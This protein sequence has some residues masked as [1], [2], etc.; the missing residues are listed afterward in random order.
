MTVQAQFALLSDR[1]FLEQFYDTEYHYGPNQE[2]FAWV[3]YQTGNAAVTFLAEPDVGRSWVS[4]THWLPKVDGYLIGQSLFDRLTYHSWGSVAYAQMD[5]FRNPPDEFPLKFDNGLPPPEHGVNTGRIDWMQKLSAPFDLGPARVVPYGVTDL[6]YFTQDNSYSTAGRVYG[7][8]GVRASVPFSRLYSDVE[9][10]MFNVKGLYHKNV[11]SVNYYAAATNLSWADLPQLDR[12]NDDATESSW[13]DITPWQ[14]A[15]SFLNATNGLVLGTGSYNIYNPRQYA[16]RRL[17]DFNPETLGNIQE[18]QL[19]WRQR[20]QTKRGYP[21][22]E[23]TVD[24]FTLDL[25]GSIFPVPNRDNFGNSVGFLEYAAQWNVGDRTALYSNAWVDPWNF[26]AR[27]WDVGASFS[28]DDRTSFAI[29][30]KNTD[31]VQSR[32]VAASATYV[33]SQ[34]Y[35]MTALTAYDFG[36]SSSLTNSLFFTRVG[37]DLM[38]TVGFT[39]NNIIKNFGMTLNIVPNLLGSQ[40]SPVVAGDRIGSSA[41]GGP[42]G[43]LSGR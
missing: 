11:F 39:Y 22:L 2:T 20:W 42:G 10:E 37:T 19:D 7:G 9:S 14:P 5:T 30:Y 24:W 40:A 3:K 31:P 43:A 32:L 21:G 8:A 26:G 41:M 16:V 33:F 23:H 38:I 27:Y 4:E 36:Y 12:L 35:A 28:R 17:V 34:K 1:N 29:T 13:R 6:A 25:S 18:V 15:Y